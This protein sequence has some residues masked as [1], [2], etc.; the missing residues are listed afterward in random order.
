MNKSTQFEPTID[1]LEAMGTQIQ[2]KQSE[3]A[4]AGTVLLMPHKQG[5]PVHLHPRQKEEF[6]IRQGELQVYRKNKWLTVKAG[7]TV[8]IPQKTPH[9]Y[10]NNSDNVV[11]FDFCI[12]PKVRFTEM[13]ESMDTLV[14]QGKIKGQDFKSIMY[15]S[16]I[17][18][19]YP[20]VTRNV[21]PP[22]FVI[23]AMALLAKLFLK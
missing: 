10:R 18:T 4:E 6:F 7:D 5:P 8:T 12:S 15:L 17:I 19:A 13:I 2:W 3:D 11:L 1:H 20:D 14:K 23:K 9:T 21:K 22:Q 16:K